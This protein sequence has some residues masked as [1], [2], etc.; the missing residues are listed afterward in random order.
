MTDM[1]EG[2]GTDHDNNNGNNKNSD[3]S[4]NVMELGVSTISIEEEMKTS[5][6]D[7][8]MSVII[9]RAIP[10][11][12]D[13]LKPVHRRILYSMN[14]SGCYYNKP[15]RK[16][17]RIVGEVMGKYHPHGDSA[18][19]DSLVRMAQDF[20]LR[21]PLVDGQ[22]NFGS[23]DGDSPA[24]MRYTESRLAKVSHLMLE[25]I[26]RNTV[27]FKD[28]YDNSGTE[29]EVIPARFPN[30]LVN[31]A[32][33]IAVGMATNIPPFN[34]GEIID[35]CCMYIKNPNMTSEDLL[36]IVQGPDFPT[37]GSILGR[38]GVISA[39]TTGR[40]SVVMRGKHNIEEKSSGKKAIIITEIPYMVNKAKMIEKIAELV[41][42]KKIEGISDLRD[43]SNKKGIRVV[44]EVKRDTVPEVILNKLY[45]YTPLQTSFGV[46]LLALDHGK[47][48]VM[49]VLEVIRLFIDFREEVVSRRI[50]FLLEKSRNKAH[51]L[52]GL[53]I[54]VNNIDEVIKLIKSSPD[55]HSAKASILSREWEANDVQKYIELV[56]DRHNTVNGTKCKFTEAQARAILEMK[57]QRLT[58]MEQTKIAHELEELAL[59]IAKYIS[60]LGS[61]EKLFEIINSE[62][63]EVKEEFADPR[64]TTIE[65]GEFEY[66]IEALIQKEDMVV[67]VTHKGYIKRCNLS[68]Y[69]SQKRGGKGRSA[70]SMREEDFTTDMFV[71]NTHTPVLFFSNYGKAYKL[72]VY[73]LPLGSTQSKG[74]AL[75]NILPLA[76]G[77]KITNVMPL[78]E[79]ET[80]WE[81]MNIMFSTSSGG[82]R[83]NDLSDFHSIQANGK[84][85][86]KMDEG[87]KL[88]DVR[89]CK[90]EDHI[91]LSAKSGKCIRFP[92][93]S[94]RV[95]KSRTSSGVRGIRLDA[96]DC[97]VSMSVLNG[98]DI[99]MESREKY[100]KVS[101]KYRS[102]ISIE[103]SDEEAMKI[104]S[105]VN[106]DLSAEDIIKY[107]KAEQFI[108]TI[109]ENGFGK[110]TSAYEYRVT[111]RGGKGIVN[112]VTS[113]RNGSVISSFAVDET[114][115]IMLITDHGTL[116]RC[117]ID[118]IRIAG[119][120]TQGVTLLRTSSESEKIVSVALI[121]ETDDEDEELFDGIDESSSAE[122]STS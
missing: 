98:M 28:N 38:S 14:E 72:K 6:L 84:I 108:L 111:N 106:S 69:R 115:Q 120:S 55:V 46:N 22:G 60:I 58:A 99:D 54:A 27:D 24:A 50:K 113:K 118:D 35:A 45:S 17:A 122:E 11:V 121:S 21:V 51:L 44:I 57:L 53:F 93:D 59:E 79:D 91:L 25:D 83:R 56:G 86:M 89:L 74:R 66:D 78:P 30:I 1:Q 65:E 41:K 104:A 5:Y 87:D 4:K 37:A 52:I 12:R 92:V 70:L 26:D 71:A 29:P 23:I 48:R 2:N 47:P 114:N 61:R 34:L 33:G 49:N 77:E 90:E 81:N 19:Y 42:D 96:S 105:K 101:L 39:I 18:V 75:V 9:S 116:I 13:G 76:D 67:T 85:A 10:D 43:E 15:Y 103:E 73:K 88:V 64:R 80:E 94:V 112:I 63:L 31:G 109:T 117:P 16:S 36:E 82:V 110:R 68:T 100:L 8:A 3:E 7:Y 97:V 32:G 95:F 107:A 20:S 119:R 102:K 40:G 62:L